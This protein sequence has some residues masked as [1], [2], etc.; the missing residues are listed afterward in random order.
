VAAVLVLGGCKIGVDYSGTE[1]QCPDGV[2]CPPGFRCESGVCVVTGATSDASGSDS[3]VDPDAS[4]EPASCG[5]PLALAES[6]GD[7]DVPWGAIETWQ[8][9]TADVS[10]GQLVMTMPSDPA[11]DAGAHLRS[12]MRT[13]LRDERVW[14]EVSEMVDTS[15]NAAAEFV[16]TN[17]WVDYLEFFQIGGVLYFKAWRADAVTTEAEVAYDPLAHRWWQF[18]DEAGTTYWETSPDGLTWTTRLTAPT[19]DL[20]T[21]AEVWMSA[22]TSPGISNPGRVVWDNLNGGEPAA[23]PFCQAASFT[24]DFGDNDPGFD[25]YVWGGNCT[26]SMAS[27]DIRLAPYANEIGYCG[28]ANALAFDLRQSSAHIEAP[29]TFA[30]GTD[31]ISYFVV[32]DFAESRA[33]IVKQ[34]GVLSFSVCKPTCVLQESIAYSPTEHRWWR[35]R[36]DGDVLNWETSADASTWTTRATATPGFALGQVSFSIGGE[37]TAANSNPGEA[38]FDNFNVVP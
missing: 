7:S 9:A 15:T 30:A 38:R 14:V 8:G 18:R 25:W 28:Y 6:F 23:E 36:G 2:T 5:G 33:D 37:T 31:A 12:H 20:A 19:P 17:G 32:H 1:Y 24:D 13:D 21:H 3:G 35:F 16:V 34:D 4:V 11:A 27:S 26:A 22:Y 10:G 29:V